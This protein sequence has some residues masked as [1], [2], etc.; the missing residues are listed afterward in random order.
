VRFLTF[1]RWI[2]PAQEDEPEITAI[3]EFTKDLK[4]IQGK[5]TAYICKDYACSEPTTSVEEML[6]RLRRG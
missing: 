1:P 3:A 2:R 4:S 5:V 6:E